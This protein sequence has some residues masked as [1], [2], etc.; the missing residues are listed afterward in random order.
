MST[1]EEEQMRRKKPPTRKRKQIGPEASI[2]WGLGIILLI[3]LIWEV[4]WNRVQL[5]NINFRITVVEGQLMDSKKDVAIAVGTVTRA[6]D[7]LIEEANRYRY[8][9]PYP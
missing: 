7:K 6:A 1:A 9:I 3:F 2:M 8:S 4:S 5:N